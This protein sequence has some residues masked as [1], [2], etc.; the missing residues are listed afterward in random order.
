MIIDQEITDRY[1]AYN[2]DCIE[3]MSAL[4]SESVHL[5]VYSPPFGGLFCYSSSDRD[6]SNCGSYEQFFDHYGFVIDE[7][8]RL[9]HPGRMTAVHCTD[10]PSG[11]TGTDYLIDFPGDIISAHKA[12]GFDFIARYA[13]WKEPLAVRNRTM[14]KN[15]A[16][17]QIVEDSSRCS[18]ASADYLLVFRR[19]GQNKIPIVHPTGLMTYAGERSM[20]AELLKYKGWTGNQIENRYS[21]WIWRQ[22]ASAFWDDIRIGRVLPFR[23]SKDEND[24][25]H[26]HALQLDVIERC[27]TLW[28]NPGETILTPFMGVG[29]EVYAAVTNDRRG[30]GI[31]LKPS[32]WRQAIKN[33]R[34]AADGGAEPKPQT[35][36]DFDDKVEAEWPEVVANV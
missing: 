18:V 2:G 23:D 12:R 16:H 33:L 10:V 14:A 9:T 21:H 27:L 25:K 35:S 7:I 36:M 19:K 30:L 17:R 5:S 6:L 13:I 1:A 32:Y 26:V 11:N 4:R 31:E 8:F 15:L 3:L 20:P 24:E 34:I 28:S 22:Y 29:S